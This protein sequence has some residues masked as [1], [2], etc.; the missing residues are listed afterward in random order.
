MGLLGRQLKPSGGATFERIHGATWV[1]GR[2][3]ALAD[4]PAT[5]TPS[6]T[7]HVTASVLD[8]GDTYFP[9]GNLA[10]V[11]DFGNTANSPFA[12]TD[13]DSGTFSG[14]SISIVSASAGYKFSGSVT[15]AGAAVHA[16]RSGSYLGSFVQNNAGTDKVVEMGGHISLTGTS[17]DASGTFAAAKV[18]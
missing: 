9:V 8:A 1:A 4:I 14:T 13:F 3:T 6:Y 10:V 2:V 17:Y 5:G 7:G 16:G 15:G 11:V 18:P 12:I